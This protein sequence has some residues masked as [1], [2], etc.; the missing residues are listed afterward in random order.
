[1]VPRLEVKQ[2]P[3]QEIDKNPDLASTSRGMRNLQT[4]MK[5]R[6]ARLRIRSA[7]EAYPLAKVSQ[8][9]TTRENNERASSESTPKRRPLPQRGPGGRFLKKKPGATTDKPKS[10]SEG[11]IVQKQ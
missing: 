9:N 8:A 7:S 2:A 1:M 4:K 6:E 3:G 11:N 10:V 5:D